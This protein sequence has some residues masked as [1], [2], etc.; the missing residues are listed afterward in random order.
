[1]HNPRMACKPPKGCGGGGGGSLS[2]KN[3][4]GQFSELVFGIGNRDT[5]KRSWWLEIAVVPPR[6]LKQ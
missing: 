6:D 2:L 5:L 1:M 4:E 3:V